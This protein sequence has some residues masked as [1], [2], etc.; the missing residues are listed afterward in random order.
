MRILHAIHDFLPRH[1][2]GSEL[3]VATLARAQ[4]VSHDVTILCAEFDPARTHGQVTWRTHDDLPVVEIVNNWAVRT[5]EDTYRPPLVGERIGQVLD[6]VQPHVVHVHN[7]FNLSFDLPAEAHR[8][9]IPVVATLHDYSLV[10]PSGG[11][12]WHA[13]EAHVCRVIETDRCARCVRESV[14]HAQ[15]AYASLAAKSPSRTILPRAAALG[16]RVAPVLVARAARTMS[17][18]AAPSVAPRDIERRL[19]RAREVMREIDLFVAPSPALA[20]EFIDLGI[21]PARMRVSDNG[22]DVW[23]DDGERAGGAGLSPGRIGTRDRP[24]RLGFVGTIVRHKGVHVLIEAM[25]ELG[26]RV[27]AQVFGS[28]DTFPDYAVTLRAA[29]DGL[30]VRF[31]GAFEP[32]RVRDIYAAFDVLVVP[33]VWIENSPLVIH[34]AFMAGVPVVASRIGGIPDLIQDGTNG[35][36]FEPAS[37]PSLAAAIR[38]LLDDPSLLARLQAQRTRVKSI[39]ENATEWDGFYRAAGAAS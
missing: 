14:F 23:R 34:E 16:R 33:S 5:F 24:L 18:V 17:K 6:A 28:M 15:A 12:R 19:A 9:N 25:R 11:Q 37:A 36:L 30:P 32:G 39:A 8:R 1:T 27:D 38:R 3:Y 22:F 13:A 35:L 7:L 31:S 2:A 20:R 21:E 4:S 29:A 26:E 10:C